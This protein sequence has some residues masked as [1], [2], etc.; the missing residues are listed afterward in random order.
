MRVKAVWSG[1]GFKEAETL[2]SG[3]EKMRLTDVFLGS[4]MESGASYRSA[5][6]QAAQ[7]AVSME[8]ARFTL[9]QLHDLGIKVHAWI[10]SLMH[11]QS[12]TH[13]HYVVNKLGSSCLDKPPYVPY[14]TWLCPHHQETREFLAGLARTLAEE[15]DFDGIHL[16]YI[17]YPDISIP[18]GL[19]KKYGLSEDFDAYYPDLDYCYCDQ[20]RDSYRTERGVD[21]LTLSYGSEGWEDWVEWRAQNVIAVVERVREEV[22]KHGL[23]LSAAVFATPGLARKSVL[24]QWARFPLDMALPMIYVRDYG[25]DFRWV[26]EAVAEGVAT[27]KRIVAGL[28]VGHYNSLEELEYSVRSALNNGASGICLFSYPGMF[29]INQKIGFENLTEYFS[30]DL[31]VSAV[32]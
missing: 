10:V 11:P 20:C 25:K 29:R 4:F 28:N 26:G 7:D 1:T 22:K 23:M 6:L 15:M 17:R 30:R 5:S 32:T 31:P 18:V 14:Y 24:Q 8:E 3:A 21:P 13:G 12:I 27:G 9:R 19:R 2:I 16:D